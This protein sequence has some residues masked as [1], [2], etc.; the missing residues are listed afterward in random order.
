M[1]DEE[2]IDELSFNSRWLSDEYKNSKNYIKY[3]ELVLD[4]LIK[5]REINE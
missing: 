1:T 2:I 5:N 3:L 4:A